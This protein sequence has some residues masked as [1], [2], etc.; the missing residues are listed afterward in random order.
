MSHL[1]SRRATGTLALLLTAYSA[2]SG[3]D[4]IHN[5]K[6]QMW[7]HPDFGETY[8]TDVP[9]FHLAEAECEQASYRPVEVEGERLTEPKAIRLAWIGYYLETHDAIKQDL[10]N[11]E[12]GYWGGVSSVAKRYGL[13]QAASLPSGNTLGRAATE[14]FQIM[15][16]PQVYQDIEAM[17]NSVSPCLAEKGWTTVPGKGPFD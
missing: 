9:E 10:E 16:H 15:E 5:L 4:P 7:H 2:L 1:I 14:I 17:M 3:C 12:Y 11:K 6:P 13:T 8:V